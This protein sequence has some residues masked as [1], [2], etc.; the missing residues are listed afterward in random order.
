MKQLALQ[1]SALT[2]SLFYI[3]AIHAQESIEDFFPVEVRSSQVG[4]DGGTATHMQSISIDGCKLVIRKS[5]NGSYSVTNVHI[6]DFVTDVEWVSSES[7]LT[8]QQHYYKRK[9]VLPKQ[10]TKKSSR[11]TWSMKSS[12]IIKDM[13]E[14]D[15]RHTPER[16]SSLLDKNLSPEELNAKA[17]AITSSLAKVKS[18]EFGSNYQ[19]NH[20]VHYS[21]Q[22]KLIEKIRSKYAN[23]AEIPRYVSPIGLFRLTVGEDSANELILAMHRFSLTC[24]AE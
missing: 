10:S 4:P 3:N 24:D 9:D 1:A 15:F 6:R 11:I 17:A 5:S 20:K 8:D 13:S 16:L 23:T 21:T 14:H 2:V 12:E 22:G 7:F 18:G 19:R